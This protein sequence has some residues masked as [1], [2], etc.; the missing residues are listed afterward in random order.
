M[1]VTSAGRADAERAAVEAEQAARVRR[2]SSSMRRGSVDR[3]LLV[4]EDVEEEAE[5]GFEAED[6]EGRVVELDFLFVAAVRRVVA[7]E[8]G[9]RAVGDAFDE[10]VDVA[11]A[12]AAAGSS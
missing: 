12:C 9:D 5:L 1:S 4:D 2:C 7:G 3:L 10:R 11:P 8:D 6:A